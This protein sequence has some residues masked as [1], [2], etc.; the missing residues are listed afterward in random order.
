MERSSGPVKQAELT[1]TVSGGHVT[2]LTITDPGQGYIMQRDALSDQSIQHI[3]TYA[4]LQQLIQI[5]HQVRLQF[6]HV[7]ILVQVMR[8][9][10]RL[11]SFNDTQGD[12]NGFGT[13][14]VATAVVTDGRISAITDN[15]CR[16]RLLCC[17][18]CQSCCCLFSY[19]SNGKMYR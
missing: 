9:Y 13:G 16:F 15:K 10:R 1:A 2:G 5:Q 8:L 12:A 6:I 11:K 3:R 19:E 17:T 18:E 4:E 7:T 14:A